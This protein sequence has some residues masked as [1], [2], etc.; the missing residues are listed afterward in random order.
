MIQ[1]RLTHLKG[2]NLT[3]KVSPHGIRRILQLAWPERSLL[4]LGFLFLILS[5]AMLLVYPQAVKQIVDDSLADGRASDINRTALIMLGVFLLQAIAGS[6]RYYYF[7]IA[8]ERI[9]ARLRSDLY[10]TVMQQ[11]IA[12]FDSRRTGELMSRLS[13]DATVLQLAASVNISMFM[14]NF[15]AAVGGLGLLIYTSPVLALCLLACIPPIGIGTIL[16]GKR[17]R[18]ISRDFQDSLAENG[19][20]AEETISGIRTVRAFS[21]ED[22][23]IGRYSQA[24]QKSFQIAKRR[25]KSIASVTAVSGIFG[26]SA[27]V[28]VLWYGGRLVTSGEMSIGDL[29]SFLLYALTV[30]VSVGA[31]GSVWTDFMSATGAAKRVFELLDLKPSRALQGGERLKSLRGE[32]TFKSVDFHYPSR[33]DYPVLVDLSFNIKPGEQVALVGP[34]GS[35]KSTIAA[36]ISRFYELETGSILLDESDLSALDGSWLREQIGVVAQDP[37][38]LSD[39]IEANI[40]YG[41]ENASSTEVATSARDAN[42]EEFILKFPEGFQTLVGERGLQLS[43]GQRQ[44]I[45]IARAMLKDPKIL[46]LDEATSALDA[47]SEFLVQEALERLMKTRTTLVIAHRL[48][49]VRKA[50]RV[51]VVQGGRIVQSGKHEDLMLDNQ[52]VYYKLVSRQFSNL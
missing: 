24:V 1:R 35:G 45:A 25:A 46:I 36:L 4:A 16:F 11:D 2:V 49:T 20:V 12:F 6:L 43:G 22:R 30:A 26:Y 38:L 37:F 51:L 31:M 9:V 40:R 34:S 10:K 5:S 8:G 42:A 47:H 33:P 48:S 23:E 13:S 28:G 17:I 41:R 39:T 21:K 27:I 3:A 44:R 18:M 32:I 29:T 15:G 50:D 14:R 7:S 52:G 19:I